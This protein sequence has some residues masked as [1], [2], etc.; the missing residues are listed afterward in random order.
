MPSVSSSRTR[1]GT[2]VNSCAP[3]DIGLAR[4]DHRGRRQGDVGAAPHGPMG[5]LTV[6]EPE[7]VGVAQPFHAVD[8]NWHRATLGERRIEMLPGFDAL[9][10]VRVAVDDPIPFHVT[11]PCARLGQEYNRGPAWPLLR[12]RNAADGARRQDE[13]T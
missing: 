1:A 2:S 12:A 6:D 13:W 10:H 8:G 3:I 7:G 11:S 4:G 5:E 9:F